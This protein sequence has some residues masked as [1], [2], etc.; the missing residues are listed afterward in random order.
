MM[1]E[2]VD[3]KLRNEI[4]PE[5]T[6]PD[7]RQLLA[8]FNKGDK[9]A[10][11]EL[12]KKH[13]QYVANLTSRLLGW[14]AEVED[15][16]QEVFVSVWENAGKFRGESAFRTWLIRITVNQCRSWKRK[17]FWKTHLFAKFKK[18]IPSS[19]ENREN[20]AITAELYSQIK[21]VVKSLP[22]KY[23]EVVVLRY[24]QE[25][26]VKQIQKVLGLSRNVI[27][28]RLS[29]ARKLLKELLKD[30]V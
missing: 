10:F 22:T 8:R 13:R 14:E 27:D 3:K 20:K 5:N 24:L 29:R 12:V 9:K 19:E 21:N 18:S 23:R 30:K 16:V 26:K 2:N 28:V 25:M 4:K 15:V 1:A 7:D 11:D 17:R 6:S